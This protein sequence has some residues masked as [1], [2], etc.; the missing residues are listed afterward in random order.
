MPFL[1]EVTLHTK[2]VGRWGLWGRR[3]PSKTH[4][5]LRK[6]PDLHNLFFFFCLGNSRLLIALLQ[7]P[8]SDCHV[9]RVLRD[10]CVV[11]ERRGTA[12]G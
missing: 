2:T 1:A 8:G 9:R 11:L 12:R 4:Q 6:L 10:V 7:G 5:D 3:K